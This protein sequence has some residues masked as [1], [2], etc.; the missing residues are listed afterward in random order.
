MTTAAISTFFNLSVIGPRFIAHIYY[1]NE[2]FPMYFTG[3]TDAEAR[4][5]AEKFAQERES[6]KAAKLAH[7]QSLSARRI[8]RAATK[9]SE[10]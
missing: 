10:E 2:A 7:A 8:G 1:N 4:E 5:K 3:A 6:A 9:E